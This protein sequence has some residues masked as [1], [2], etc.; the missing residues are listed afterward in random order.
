MVRAAITGI[1][2]GTAPGGKVGQGSSCWS[3]TRRALRP[4]RPR[5]ADL[6]ECW[7]G[8]QKHVV[9]PFGEDVFRWGT[10]ARRACLLASARRVLPDHEE[11]LLGRLD[12]SFRRRPWCSLDSSASSH[13]HSRQVWATAVEERKEP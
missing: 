5:P 13:P 10:Q 11:R 12:R 8:D 4:P 1:G 6:A 2:I 3:T 9:L 7:C